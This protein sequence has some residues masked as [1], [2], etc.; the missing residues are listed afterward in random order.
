MIPLM[1]QYIINNLRIFFLIYLFDFQRQLV[2]NPTPYP[3]EMRAFANILR[4]YNHNNQRQI[5][6]SPKVKFLEYFNQIFFS[7]SF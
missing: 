7:F 2:R 1:N 3:K 6:Q 4:N 5:I